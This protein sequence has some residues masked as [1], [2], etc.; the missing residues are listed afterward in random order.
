MYITT[1]SYI[2]QCNY[3]VLTLY[4][5]TAHVCIKSPDLKLADVFYSKIS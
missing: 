1:C 4:M 5:L 2:V 3:N